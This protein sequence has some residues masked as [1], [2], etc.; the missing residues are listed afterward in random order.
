MFAEKE[1]FAVL[2]KFC[3]GKK[4]LPRERK[5]AVIKTRCP[6]NLEILPRTKALSKEFQ[7]LSK[8]LKILPSIRK[9]C[10]DTC[11]PS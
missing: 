3:R 4:V 7:V 8:E 1:S 2:K 11:G 5:F 9:F 6:E 10:R